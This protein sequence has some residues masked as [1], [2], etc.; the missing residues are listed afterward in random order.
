MFAERL[1]LD[2]RAFLEVARGSL[3]VFDR[4]PRAGLTMPIDRFFASLATFFQTFFMFDECM[5][6]NESRRH[7]INGNHTTLRG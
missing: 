7:F 6:M 4:D 5:Q 1:G 2:P 3:R